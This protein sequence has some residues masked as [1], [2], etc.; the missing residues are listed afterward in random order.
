MQSVFCSYCSSAE[1]YAK[2]RKPTISSVMSD[3]PQGTARLPLDGFSLNLILEDRRTYRITVIYMKTDRRTYRI[4]VIYMKTD[5]CTYRI[6]VIYM[7][8][9]RCTYTITPH[10]ILLRIRN[11]SVK[12]CTDN[13][14]HILCS[15]TLFRKSCRL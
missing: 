1:A 15:A 12:N 8:T 3:S 11:I 4:T 5:R 9:D 14:T 10:R 7:K 2:L 13:Q 6:T